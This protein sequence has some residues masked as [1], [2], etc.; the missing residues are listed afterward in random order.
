MTEHTLSEQQLNSTLGKAAPNATL[1]IVGPD[2]PG[3]EVIFT[4]G[5]VALLESLCREFAGEV[6]V[7]LAKRK[8]KQARID[9]GGLPDFLPETRA[10]RMVRGKS[11]G[12]QQIFLTVESKLL[13]PLN[14]KW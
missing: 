7:L 9:K 3:Q 13:A 2:I 8:E 10:I 14:V 4:D 5:A 11:A 12:S 6:P 1:D